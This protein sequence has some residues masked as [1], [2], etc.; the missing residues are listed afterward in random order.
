MNRSLAGRLASACCLL[1]AALLGLAGCS[2]EE[3]RSVEQATTA[4]STPAAKAPEIPA[5]DTTGM[6]A[7]AAKILSAA[8]AAVVAN[9]EAAAWQQLGKACDAF[10]LLEC[11]QTSYSQSAHLAPREFEWPYLLAGI[12]EAQGADLDEVSRYYRTAAELNPGYAA[13]YFRLGEA[14]QRAGDWD[15]ARITYG[16]AL[17]LVPDVAIVH[18]SLGRTLNSLGRLEEAV[19]HLERARDIGPADVGVYTSLASAYAQLGQ[20][21]RASRANEQAK[22]LTRVV[23]LPD[24][25]RLEIK[26]LVSSTH[27]RR[28][29]IEGLLREGDHAGVISEL[30]LAIELEPDDAAL[31]YHLGRSLFSIG[32]LDA[33]VGPLLRAVELEPRHHM[34]NNVL[35]A[36][37]VSKGWHGRA[38]EYY[39]L[40]IGD[41]PDVAE[42]HARL[43]SALA[44]H[45]RPSEAVAE[46]ARADELGELNDKAHLEWG[47]A[48]SAAGDSESAIERYRAALAL[49]PNSVSANVKLGLH[50]EATGDGAAAR[51]HYRRALELEPSNDIGERLAALELLD[52]AN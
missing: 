40:C 33:A 12:R 1:A 10:Q 23:A 3:P 36:I 4:S 6:N 49:E 11:A 37:A 34:A 8:H 50:F 14:Q 28:V 5:I 26:A 32:Q 18:L 44:R 13:I 20:R 43:A 51:R 31:H 21:E 22:G 25:L 30:R 24:P 45:G 27:G 17:A 41:A 38:I 29:K 42:Y 9:P 15:A 35:G 16:K 39:R 52:D 7:H 46:F 47:D 48:L 2:S 19:E